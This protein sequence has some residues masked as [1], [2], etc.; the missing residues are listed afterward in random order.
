MVTY[1]YINTVEIF[2]CAWIWFFSGI[3]KARG[4]SVCPRKLLCKFKVWTL[5]KYTVILTWQL[6]DG[7][8][9]T[10]SPLLT[11]LCLKLKC[12]DYS[13]AISNIQMPWHAQFFFQWYC[14]FLHWQLHT[15]FLILLLF[16][17]TH[18]TT[19][20]HVLLMHAPG[21]AF[22][23]KHEINEDCPQ[24]SNIFMQFRD[25]SKLHIFWVECTTLICF[26]ASI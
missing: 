18:G 3:W 22:Q 16:L 10:V 25:W 24:Q 21:L 23:P 1:A 4:I 20:G 15:V 9:N 5:Y 2:L 14:I 8:G 11:V 6:S 13:L 12:F 17:Q 26:L 19:K 7:Q